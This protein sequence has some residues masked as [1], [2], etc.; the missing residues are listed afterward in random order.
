MLAYVDICA[1][2]CVSSNK[3]DLPAAAIGLR[4]HL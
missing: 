1:I 4:V 3:E 2:G